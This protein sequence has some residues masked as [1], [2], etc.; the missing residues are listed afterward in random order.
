MVMQ[1]Y[2]IYGGILQYC[3]GKIQALVVGYHARWLFLVNAKE[4]T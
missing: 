4:T 1:L 3:Y 2:N